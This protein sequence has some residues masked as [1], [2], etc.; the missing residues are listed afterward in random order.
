[1][2]SRSRRDV[3]VR[4]AID[5]FERMDRDGKDRFLLMLVRSHWQLVLRDDARISIGQLLGLTRSLSAERRRELW[6]WLAAQF[7]ANVGA[8]FEPTLD[9]EVWGGIFPEL[10]K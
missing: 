7:D 3:F 5:A 4:E 2:G 8:D 9:P 10:G 6:Q 1:M